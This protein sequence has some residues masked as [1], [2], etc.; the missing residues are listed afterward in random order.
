MSSQRVSHEPK[1]RVVLGEDQGSAVDVLL[2]DVVGFTLG[3]VGPRSG[4]C[5]SLSV[6]L[7]SGRSP[8]DTE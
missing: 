2:P 1:V 3:L 7:A 6:R 4:T 8:L 5:Y